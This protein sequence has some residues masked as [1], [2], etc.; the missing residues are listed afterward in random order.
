MAQPTQK[1]E[2]LRESSTCPGFVTICKRMKPVLQRA[3]KAARLS[4]TIGIGKQ[5]LACAIHH[6][7]QKD[8]GFVLVTVHCTTIMGRPRITIWR[9]LQM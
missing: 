2:R 6:L 7:H 5:A 3:H 4:D 8:D 1:P 9:A